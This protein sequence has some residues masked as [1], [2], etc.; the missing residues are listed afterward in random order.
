MLTRIALA[1]LLIGIVATAASAQK[2]TP[3]PSPSPPPPKPGTHE[4][5]Q[6]MTADYEKARA[7]YEALSNGNASLDELRAAYDAVLGGW[8]KILEAIEDEGAATPEAKKAEAATDA[9][10][11]KYDDEFR[12]HDDPIKEAFLLAEFQAAEKRLIKVLSAQKAALMKALTAKPPEPSKR[13]VALQEEENR[14]FIEE[15]RKREEAEEAEKKAKGQQPSP[16]PS[17]QQQGSPQCSSDGGLTGAMNNLACQ[18]QHSG[19]GHG[20]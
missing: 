13:H 8:H 9:A 5:T 15:E 11:K 1:A 12:R 10:L 14:K 2:A 3:T 16:Q 18:E 6:A 19:S 20:G 4:Y 7:K 17:P